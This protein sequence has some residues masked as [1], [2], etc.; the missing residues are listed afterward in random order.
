MRTRK[1]AVLID[2]GFFIKRLPKLVRPDQC[3]TPEAV[4]RAASALCKRHVRKLTGE[5]GDPA[6]S[7][8]LDH[9][10]RLFY[11]DAAPHTALESNPLT[12]EQI[13]Y[14]RLPGTEF[15]TKLFSELRRNRKFALRLGKLS[16]HDGWK[17]KNERLLKRML[18]TKE[19]LSIFDAALSGQPLP[20]LT[21]P[22][23][24]KLEKVRDFWQ[25]L[26]PTDLKL[27]L[28]Q[29]GVDMRIGVDISTL[30]LKKQVDTIILVT[31]D[32]DFVPAAKVARRE[33]VEFLLDPM[34]QQV[35]DDLLEHVDGI[36]SGFSRSGTSTI[37]EDLDVSASP[38]D[39]AP[40]AL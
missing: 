23:L 17:L 28:R 5:K 33:G 27:D 18:K 31:G 36:V 37:D 1:I 38:A 25:T 10:Y 13:H 29:K 35:N 39:I 21:S 2:G 15:R 24:L 11:Y 3:A 7:R 40:P 22:E 26:A 20:T 30:T 32:S 6:K 12:H 19:W 14:S 34:W 9:V 8:W 4:A 16:S